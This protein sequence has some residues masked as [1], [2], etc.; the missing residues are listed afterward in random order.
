MTTADKNHSAFTAIT[1]VQLAVRNSC[2]STLDFNNREL[3]STKFGRSKFSLSAGGPLSVTNYAGLALANIYIW[4]P[5]YIPVL[6]LLEF[7]MKIQGSCIISPRSIVERPYQT[8]WKWTRNPKSTHC[9][10][11]IPKKCCASMNKHE[12]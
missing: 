4:I 2:G 8:W 1:A 3:Y 11:E 12:F 9:N 6:W 5:L 7:K 10:K